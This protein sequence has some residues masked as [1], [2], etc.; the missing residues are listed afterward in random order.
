MPAPFHGNCLQSVSARSSPSLART[1]VKTVQADSLYE[2]L[3]K[4]IANNQLTPCAIVLSL[5][6]LWEL[7]GRL[8]NN[9]VGWV[10]RR[11]QASR[12]E[13]PKALDP[14]L[15]LGIYADLANL[16]CPMFDPW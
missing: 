12:L 2:M 3:G 7:F 11:V 9:L 5:I 8:S 13:R 14:S 6:D 1:A 10:I 16:R 4:D 15:L